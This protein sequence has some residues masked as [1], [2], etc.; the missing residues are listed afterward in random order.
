LRDLVQGLEA[1][2]ADTYMGL[3]GVFVDREPDAPE[4]YNVGHREWLFDTRN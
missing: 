3:M 4:P 2:G 1:R